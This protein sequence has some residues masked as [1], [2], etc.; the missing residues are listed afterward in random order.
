MDIVTVIGDTITALDRQAAQLTYQMVL[1]TPP[2]S[3]ALEQERRKLLDERN[4]LDARQ[5]KLV[6]CTFDP[7]GPSAAAYKDL[8]DS[9]KTLNTG[10]QQTIGDIKNV[11]Q[12]I[13]IA[14]SLIG[15]VDELLKLIASLA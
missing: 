15:V 6:K 3:D 13:A 11:Q 14:T 4:A 1:A 5:Q 8:T 2:A 9:I 10:L 7:N 12:T